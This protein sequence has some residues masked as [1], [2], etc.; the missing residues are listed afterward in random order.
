[1]KCTTLA[2][3]FKIPKPLSFTEVIKR[4]G[5]ETEWI[6]RDCEYSYDSIS[7]AIMKN[8]WARIFKIA[9]NLFLVNLTIEVERDTDLEVM[10]EEAKEKLFR[11]VLPLLDAREIKECEPEET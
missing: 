1:M 5:G 8:A 3:L 7:G 10:I 6:E 2:W 4:L 11:D 9:L